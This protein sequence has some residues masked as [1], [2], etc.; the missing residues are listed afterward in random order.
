MK[1]R[2]AII[3]DF[4]KQ[5]N[6]QIIQVSQPPELKP[7]EVLIKVEA[8]TVSATDSLIRKGIYPLLKEKTPF[9]LGYDFVGRIEQLG[10]NVTHW[11]IGDRVADVCMTGGN[12]DYIIR[13]EQGLLRVNEAL[14]AEQAACL[15]MSGMTGYQIFKRFQLKK[16]QS[17]LIHGGAGAVGS[18]LLQLCSLYG[19]HAVSTGSASKL[20]FIRA[21]H[22]TALDYNDPNYFKKLGEAA[23]NGF[24]A[25]FDFTNQKSFN[26]SFRLLKKGG[27]LV[28]NA[29]YTSGRKINKK[30]LINFLGFGLD[31]G[32]MMIKLQWWNRMPN[33]KG[34]SF[35]GVLDSKRLAPEQYQTDFD[36]LQQLVI[37]K[38]IKVS[39]HQVFEL[40]D[41]K[42]AHQVLEE[43]EAIGFLVINN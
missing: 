15:V 5:D 35:Y 6:I 17:A 21:Q 22:E 23:K 40:Q 8:S 34:A 27:I 37:Q 14:A 19:I 26:H 9:T 10:S 18:M 43:S 11:K 31:F 28:T 1:W 39:I 13:P 30:N 38:K 12:A 7:N 25:A 33:G 32:L 20:Q 4:G 16:G 42:K 3:S 24:D 2:K 29:V 36:A 41:V